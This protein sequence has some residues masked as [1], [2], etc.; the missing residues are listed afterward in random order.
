MNKRYI[1]LVAGALL[2]TSPV[3]AVK[4]ETENIQMAKYDEKSLFQLQKPEV[5][6]DL[7]EK[8][9]YYNVSGGSI[10]ELREQ[11]KQN[12]TRWNDDRTYAALTTWNIK[13]KFDVAENNG[14]YSIG[15]VNTKLDIVYRYPRLASAAGLS[16]QVAGQWS[17]YMGNVNIHEIGHRDIS[18]KAAA[19]INQALSELGT[20]GSR[21][22]L[23]KSADRIVEARLKR[24]KEEQIKYDDDTHHGITQGAILK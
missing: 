21:R 17:N 15:S 4:A 9:E 5:T 16:E 8:H 14:R 3:L 11:M 19:D 13:Y 23:N 1:C 7:K 24:L 22:E 2:C 18:A 20:F 12:G 10:A 6:L